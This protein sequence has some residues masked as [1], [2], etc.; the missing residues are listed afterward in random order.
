MKKLV[1][2]FVC[3]FAVQTLVWADGEKPIQVDQM[4][5]RAQQFISQYFSGNAVTLAKVE[6][7]FLDKSYDVIFTNGD[8]LE[9]NKKGE[10]TDV[11]CRFSQV[12]ADIIPAAIQSYVSKQYPNAKILKIERDSR[13]YEV[14]L[15]DGWEIEFDK[16]FNV[17]DIDR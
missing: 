17:I 16:K 6:T 14:K 5:K 1:F 8:K 3:L 11:D 9:F 15:S 13:T 12:P 4:P 2:L 7:D 10:W